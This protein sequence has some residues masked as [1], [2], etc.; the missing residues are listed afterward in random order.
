MHR[1]MMRRPP[2]YRGWGMMGPGYGHHH[3]FGYQG[4]GDYGPGMI[5]GY[6]YN[7]ADAGQRCAARFRSFEIGARAVIR[8]IAARHASAPI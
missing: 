4:K 8:P 6:G 5:W 7:H 1:L 3:S 2:G